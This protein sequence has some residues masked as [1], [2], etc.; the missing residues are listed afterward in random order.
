MPKDKVKKNYEVFKQ[1]L[2]EM[3]QEHAGEFVV[4]HEQEI[5][6]YFDTFE[7]AWK[8]SRGKFEPETFIIQRVEKDVNNFIMRQA[9]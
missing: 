1:H 2:N 8:W 5:K 7:D 4:I 9:V 6:E 3:M